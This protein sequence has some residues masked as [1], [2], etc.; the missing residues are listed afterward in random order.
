MKVIC[1][2]Y[3]LTISIG[4]YFVPFS[5]GIIHRE[6]LIQTD[7]SRIQE[8]LTLL[9]ITAGRNIIGLEDEKEE[10]VENLD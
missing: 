10:R 7:E 1:S 9:A 2:I 6:L 3:C 8:D 4:L 5:I